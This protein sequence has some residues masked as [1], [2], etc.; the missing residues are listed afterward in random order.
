MVEGRL[1]KVEVTLGRPV[2]VGAR[3]GKEI[4][5]YYRWWGRG[6]YEHLTRFW[7]ENTCTSETHFAGAGGD[8]S[9][10]RI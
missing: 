8:Q 3:N 9:S 2:Q 10:E 1:V 7:A 4:V 5:L 6:W